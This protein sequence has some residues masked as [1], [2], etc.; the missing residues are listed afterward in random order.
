MHVQGCMG[1]HR[2]LR[3]ISFSLF[4][5]NTGVSFQ[6]NGGSVKHVYEPETVCT[7]GVVLDVGHYIH[8]FDQSPI[9]VQRYGMSDPYRTYRGCT[10][11]D[12]HSNFPFLMIVSAHGTVPGSGKWRAEVGPEKFDGGWMDNTPLN[13]GL[14][15]VKICVQG[16]N[17][18]I[19]KLPAPY[20]GMKVAEV[21]IQLLPQW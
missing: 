7:I 8:I 20:V 17:V 18:E 21:V 19:E 12:I 14:N 15:R 5:I 1:V 6:I 16:E 9:K 3:G 13:P 11:T 4:L 2:F 10:V